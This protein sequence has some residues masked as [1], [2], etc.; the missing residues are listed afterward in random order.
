MLRFL[1]SHPQVHPLCWQGVLLC[2]GVY[3]CT[4]RG[5]GVSQIPTTRDAEHRLCPVH[6]APVS[7]PGLAQLSFPEPRS[8]SGCCCLQIPGEWCSRD[9]PGPGCVIPTLPEPRDQQGKAPALGT[10]PAAFSPSS[11]LYSV[12]QRNIPASVACWSKLTLHCRAES[13]A[14]ESRCWLV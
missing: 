8:P 6:G 11:K 5:G 14:L 7:Q 12:I 1:F 4:G 10:P 3:V 13:M 2:G 9:L